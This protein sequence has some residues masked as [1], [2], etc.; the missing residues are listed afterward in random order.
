[1]ALVSALTNKLT[2]GN[3]NGKNHSDSDA[4]LLN[5]ADP[6][7]MRVVKREGNIVPYDK[8][9]IRR[10]VGLC[11]GSVTERVGDITP[12]IV[13]DQVDTILRLK[14]LQLGENGH[15]AEVGIE[16]IQDIVE[17]QFMALGQ[18]EAAK[19]YILY[20]DERRRVR[21]ESKG[22]SPETREFFKEGCSLFTG[23]NRLLQEV[24]AFDK[25]SRFR[26][27]FSPK[28]RETW[29]ESC[30]RVMRHYRKHVEKVAPGAIPEETWQEL[31]Q[32]LLY[33]RATGSLRGVQMAGPALERCASG[34]YNCSFLFMDSPES[35][36][37]DL[38]LLMQGCGVG[39]SVEEEYAIDKWP[40][41]HA[42]RDCAPVDYTVEDDTEAWCDG[43]KFGIHHWLDGVDVKFDLSPIRSAGS[44]LKTKGG[45]ASG[46]APLRDLLNFDR[47]LI[48]RRERQRLRSIDVHDMTCMLHRV[49]QMGGVRRASGISFSDRD[50]VLMRDAKKGE[51]FNKYPWRNQANNSAVYKEKPTAVEF[52]EEWLTLAKS[53]SGERGIFNE[54][55][56]K[57]QIPT[58]RRP[59]IFRGN[60]CMEIYLRDK[61]FC[62]LS[63]AIVGILDTLEEI[64]E[65]VVLATIWGTIQASMT[66]FRYLR[67]QWKKNCEEEALLGVDILGHMDCKLLKPGATGRE[68]ILQRLRQV[69]IDTNVYWA[70]RLGINSG[71][72]LTC[73]KP[74]GDSSVFFDKAAGLKAHHG[75]F[76][77]RRIRLEETNPVATV[78]KDA[79]IPWQYDYD[80]TGIC[81]FEFPCKAP[82]GAIILGDMSAVE[83]LENWKVWKV[84]FTE[85][86][87][88]CTINVK[89]HEWIEAGNWV[90][91]NWDIVGGL[92]FYP[93]DDAVY[94]LTPYERIDEQEY[95][96]R[97]ANMP[98]EIDWSRILLYEHEDET[99]LSGQLACSGPGC[100]L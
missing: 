1:M 18:F 19:H 43:L 86:N 73:G 11:F 3:S 82:E 6:S 46:P 98:D 29:P 69:V 14:A 100:D 60:P 42:R 87:P 45:R 38:Y 20:R 88:S 67:D 33:Q 59:G 76:W 61:N 95:I 23:T 44:L 13:T 2:N 36:A 68:E 22:V 27:D 80:K 10:A 25:F 55:S 58:R 81:V 39:F 41:V 74:S 12:Q 21:E 28:R 94:P 53:G 34:V 54:G 37:E 5:L 91:Q 17:A 64:I 9:K 49:G 56:L 83:Q 78:L 70:R 32:G 7:L 57:F 15:L 16:A 92:S 24:Q 72:A 51:F 50:D 52:M 65:K 85:H 99:T 31:H 26:R 93:H 47:D 63:I 48:F 35:M 4:D 97:S 30:D 8:E 77:I 90:Y 62:N 40:R 66:E 79:K 75:R 71:A 96:Q 89:D 84:N